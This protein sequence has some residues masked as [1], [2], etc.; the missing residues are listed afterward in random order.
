MSAIKSSSWKIIFSIVLLLIF[1]SCD[2]KQEKSSVPK[3][4]NE[5]TF[6][7]VSHIGGKLGNYKIVKATKD[8]ISL[9]QG[10]TSS[11]KHQYWS[12]PIQSKDWQYLASVL[13]VKT[14][15]SIK[16][17]PSTI[18]GIDETF[19]IRTPKR[20]HI[21]VNSYYDTIHYKQLQKLKKRIEEILP[22]E[23]Q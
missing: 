7:S 17:S 23:Y 12:S 6:I 1:F 3:N 11:K 18:D 19:Q 13:N 14:L 15:D 21:Y 20:A 10:V 8:S 5:I 4:P 16:S 9:E 22:K 2:N